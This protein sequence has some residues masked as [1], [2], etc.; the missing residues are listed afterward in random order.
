MKLV[1]NGLVALILAA[2]AA[3]QGAAAGIHG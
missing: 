3:T 2:T 1:H